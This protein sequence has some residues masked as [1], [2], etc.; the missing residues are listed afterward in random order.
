LPEGAAEG[1]WE[2]S[3]EYIRIYREGGGYDICSSRIH[4]QESYNSETKEL[5]FRDLNGNDGILQDNTFRRP[6]PGK[7]WVN[8]KSVVVLLGHAP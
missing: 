7:K 5:E 8:E 6:L 1:L 4:N 3:T 2:A